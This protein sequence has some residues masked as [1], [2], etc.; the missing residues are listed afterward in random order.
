MAGCLTARAQVTNFFDFIVS[1]NIIIN[2]SFSPPYYSLTLNSAI[3]PVMVWQQFGA[4]AIPAL[5]P[6]FFYYTGSTFYP[7]GQAQ[8]GFWFSD[9]VNMMN[10][11]VTDGST[12]WIHNGNLSISGS[13][14]ALTNTGDF[15]VL[16]GSN[17]VPGISLTQSILV[18][19]GGATNI[20]TNVFAH[21]LLVASGPAAGFPPSYIQ[22]NGG[23]YL[24]PNG[25]SYLLP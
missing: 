11:W 9:K 7:G 13:G 15:Y 3:S 12:N 18:V 10:G 25:G 22:P 6:G 21:G 24:Q 1:D 17:L 2:T 5:G 20:Y 14:A 4:G 16:Q 8:N 19:S 23:Y